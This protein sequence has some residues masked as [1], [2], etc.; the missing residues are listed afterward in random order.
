L[1]DLERL[2]HDLNAD[3]ERIQTELQLKEE[4]LRIE[5]KEKENLEAMIRDMELKLVNGG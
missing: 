1:E 3:K 2:K 5:A 4:R